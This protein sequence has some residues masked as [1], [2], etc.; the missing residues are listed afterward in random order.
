MTEEELLILQQLILEQDPTA[1]AANDWGQGADYLNSAKKPTA[2]SRQ[3]DMHQLYR[4]MFGMTGID[5]ESLVPNMYPVVDKPEDRQPYQS[6]TLALYQGN[7]A[8]DSVRETVDSGV[9]SFEEAVKAAASDPELAKYLP[10][11]MDGKLDL[12]SFRQGAAS[13]VSEGAKAGREQSAYNA[14]QA[15]YDDYVRMRTGEDFVPARKSRD[16]LSARV[17]QGLVGGRRLEDLPGGRGR[18]A[19]ARPGTSMGASQSLQALAQGGSNAVGNF[20]GNIGDAISQ[21]PGKVDQYIGDP[22]ERFG[23]RLGQ[24]FNPGEGAWDMEWNNP[25]AGSRPGITQ[26]RF[27][28]AAAGP[29]G[30]TRPSKDG[31]KVSALGTQAAN[32]AARQGET[33]IGNRKRRERATEM[34]RR[35]LAS[36][37]AGR[38]Q[39][40]LRSVQSKEQE[41]NQRLIAFYN[42]LM[43]QG[44]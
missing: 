22:V 41:N 33:D 2:F 27:D 25:A 44:G 31:S 43:R 7:P 1:A 11:D 12:A 5:M 40:A 9:L 20:F 26:S 24:G 10:T 23:A 16:E 6:D 17:M 29:K 39:L 3:G 8:Y 37:D 32:A 36:Y 13:Y 42:Q 28:P 19:A 4:N 35:R 14:E 30:K 18:S 15:A 21:V 38:M 34:D